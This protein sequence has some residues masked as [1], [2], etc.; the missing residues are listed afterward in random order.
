MK[1]CPDRRMGFC[2]LIFGGE[3]W[4]GGAGGVGGTQI[5]PL[6]EFSSH[7]DI[8]NVL[9]RKKVDFNQKNSGYQTFFL[10]KKCFK[11]HFNYHLQHEANELDNA[12][13]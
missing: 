2:R 1:T 9:Q 8:L 6:L 10:A 13:V 3:V 11:L 7:S 4:G 5:S 12:V